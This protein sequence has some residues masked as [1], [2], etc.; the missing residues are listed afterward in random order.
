MTKESQLKKMEKNYDYLQN[1]PLVEKLKKKINTLK[2]ENKSL[3]KLLLHLSDSIQDKIVVDL[4]NLDCN[5]E[6]NE[7]RIV[8]SIEE[9]KDRKNVN[10]KNEVQLEIIGSK[11]P[12]W[13]YDNIKKNIQ[14]ESEKFYNENYSTTI[15]DE[16]EAT[17]DHSN[18][19][20]GSLSEE[21]EQESEEE[22]V[23]DTKF[24]EPIMPKNIDA[25]RMSFWNDNKVD[26]TA[27]EL[28]ESSENFED[29]F[30]G[31]FQHDVEEESEEESEE[32]EE[33]FE[34][35]IRGKKY[36]T[37]NTTNGEIYSITSDGDIGDEIGKYHKG[38][39]TWY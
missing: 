2:K 30:D 22:D 18:T 33:V 5:E 6:N 37:T 7:E 29:P 12:E 31:D 11:P 35:T 20:N 27:P 36:F 8:Y 26:S 14:K 23:S 15:K 32:E 28:E 39:V 4:T 25:E 1:L 16:Y 13:D 38:K 9:T 21:E 34:V 10:F 17:I 19:S 3:N 24:I